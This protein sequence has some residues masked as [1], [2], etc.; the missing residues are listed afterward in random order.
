MKTRKL[1]YGI[2]A[3][4][5]LVGLIPVFMVRPSAARLT[6]P[7]EI[8]RQETDG[9]MRISYHSET[10]KVRFIG[11]DREH[12]MPQPSSLTVN[13]SVDDAARQFLAAYGSAFGLKDQAQELAVI[14]SNST[15]DG[16][17]VVR[18]Q[19]I[20]NGIPVVGGELVVQMDSNK[21]VLSVGGE[22]LPDLA[23]ETT[24][25]LDAETARQ[26]AIAT[27]ASKYGVQA[28]N[29]TTTTPELWIYNPILL[30]GPGPRISTLVWRMDV[31]PT[32][33]LPIQELVLI[34]AHTGIVALHFNQIDTARNRMTYDANNGSTLPGTLVCNEA[35]PTCAAGAGDN[36]AQKAHVYAGATY[37][38]YSTYHGR[39]SI[40]NHGMTIIS[41]VHYQVNYNNAF[42][43]G[44]QMVYGDENDFANADDVVAHELTHGVTQYESGLFY[45]YQAGAINESFS[46]VWG[47]FVD[48]T[49]SLGT[50]TPAVKWL[51]GEDVTGLGAFRNMADPT[52][53]C[54]GFTPCYG[55]PQPDKM[56]SPYY[57]CTQGDA[58][59]P[60]NYDNGGVH[61]NSGVNNKAAF[62]M[63]Q[64]GSFN[65]QN[66]T[67]LGI[68]KVAKIYYEVQTNLLTSA[69]DYEDL[70]DDLQQACSILTGTSGITT[71][72]CQQVQKAVLA[73]QMNTQPANCPATEAPVCPAGQVPN[74]IFFD[75]LENPSSGNWSSSGTNNQWYYPQ[76]TNPYSF[77]AT[78]ATSGIY[79][80]WGY[81][82][83]ALGDYSMTMNHNVS[84][85]A[86][87][88]YLRF[89]HAYGFE[90]G[91]ADGGVIEYSANGEAWT[92]AGALITDGGIY[93]GVISGSFGN[94]LGGRNGF[95]NDSAGYISSRLNLSSLA[96]QNVK[97]RFRM[98]T[99]GSGPWDFGWFIDD[100][101]IY[102]CKTPTP[103]GTPTKTPTR[104]KTP[105]ITPTPIGWTPPPKKARFMP[106]IIKPG[107]PTAT[108]TPTPTPTFTPT[109]LPPIKPGLWL[110]DDVDCP[111]CTEFYIT[112]DGAKVDDFA[113]YIT[114]PGCGDYTVTHTLLEPIN[115][116]AFAFTG[117]FYASGTFD[118]YTTAHGSEGF[119]NFYIDGCGYIN[120]SFTYTASWYDSSQPLTGIGKDQS[121][122]VI[123]VLPD[124][125]NGSFRIEKV[126]P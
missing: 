111:G 69:G 64:G 11:T 114:V 119:N 35:D 107:L 41:S 12:P 58:Q 19:Q 4:L 79:N 124:S 52:N 98:G 87:T 36:D 48:Q 82:G 60:D 14:S 126:E 44:S 110:E 104:T 85:P 6:D 10:G 45:Y 86:G 20:S 117:P 3:I 62:L 83:T 77:N 28:K 15:E 95:V 113:I 74:N 121:F 55:S 2:V 94:P 96:T 115:N 57:F 84:L 67:G 50:D 81:D 1:V 30:G 61:T 29:L 47:E 80:F 40:D 16:R 99:D 68:T 37:D 26:Y 112:T 78:Y 56:S 118:S 46:D 51:I 72:D 97:F 73:V 31:L 120:G 90:D 66:V 8:L 102:T 109:T 116:M 70:Y 103:T 122:N 22:V 100:I 88:V 54:G 125:S 105:T 18:F 9:T 17:A 34:E 76:N 75:N 23:L 33:L 32:E 59:L 63:T 101:Q 93:G 49:D 108:P 5:F 43:S 39:D 24:P 38:F 123:E 53:P 71:T 21:A 7:V 106:I 65:S 42:W 92:D 25:S 13:T 89:N 27:V 91:N